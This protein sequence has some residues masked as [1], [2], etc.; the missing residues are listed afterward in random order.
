M[1]K[2]FNIGLLNLASSG[3]ETVHAPGIPDPAR[4]LC[5]AAT[6]RL[7]PTRRAVNCRRCGPQALGL[8][9]FAAW[10]EPDGSAV[11]KVND[12]GDTVAVA[13]RVKAGQ[14]GELELELA[15]EPGDLRRFAR[16]VNSLADKY[17]L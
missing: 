2:L 11:L 14:M 8:D 17:A 5:G 12:N 16:L 4:P 9:E 6:Q 10:G 13:V 7:T 3:G 15:L 1:T